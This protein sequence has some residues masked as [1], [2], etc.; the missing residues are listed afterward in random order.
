MADP[1]ALAAPAQCDVLWALAV[2]GTL[3]HD[4]CARLTAQLEQ[5]P[6]AEFRPEVPVIAPSPA[7]S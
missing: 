4:A 6:L 3:T 7:V 2:L 5:R 1:G